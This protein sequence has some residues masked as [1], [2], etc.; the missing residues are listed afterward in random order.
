MKKITPEI[1]SRAKRIKQIRHQR[2][3]QEIKALGQLKKSSAKTRIFSMLF[4]LSVFIGFI[5]Y[6]FNVDGVEKINYILENADY[7]WV[8]FGLIC[9][10]AEWTFE[11]FSMH[12]PLK[13]MY[14][15]HKFFLSFKSN[16]IGKLFNNI[17]PFSSGGQPFQAYMLNKNG[18]RISDTLSVLVM[19]FIVYQVALFSWAILLLIINFNFFN[20]TFSDYM[21]LVMLGFILNLVATLFV[22]LCGINKNLILKIA[23]PIIKLG[24]K[25]KLGKRR[26][27]KDLD[28]TLQKFDESATN[29]NMQ[30]NEMKNQKKTIVR[31]YAFSM[32]QLL[33]YFSIP[34]MIYKAFG[35]IGT[36]YI[37]IL[38][39]QTY[40]LLIMSFIPT[41]GSGLG[42]EGGF[43]LLYG[44][45]FVNGLNMAILF[46]RGYTYYLPI[47][48]GTILLLFTNRRE[49][50]KVIKQEL[51]Q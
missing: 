4:I 34:F 45:V 18:L 41:P 38:T 47:I 11:T 3:K 50:N 39:V 15:K 40:L 32:L 26:L 21:W 51:Q 37:E 5:I 43:A 10:C 25:I 48:I 44:T 46:W 2:L 24:A 22:I 14:P 1:I 23:N 9:V 17:T 35:N 12:I 42:A 31:M 33:A 29:Y 19:K 20:E 13:K 30:F 7:K 8:L 6:T 36:S 27:V 28:A 49:T 16:I